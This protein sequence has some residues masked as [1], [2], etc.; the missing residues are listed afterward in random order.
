M[1]L[2][3]RVWWGFFFIILRTEGLYDLKRVVVIC[4]FVLD[5]VRLGRLSGNA[6]C[7]LFYILLDLYFMELILC[8]SVL[9]RQVYVFFSLF[10]HVCNRL[11]PISSFKHSLFMFMKYFC[12]WFPLLILVRLVVV[13]WYI[14]NLLYRVVFSSSG[15]A[16]INIFMEN[17]LALTSVLFC[18]VLFLFYIS[19]F[20][21]LIYIYIYIYIGRSKSP[22]KVISFFF[23]RKCF[24]Y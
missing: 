11:D 14:L 9:Q 18:F 20:L 16:L 3:S 19:F 24:F 6:F 12:W 2:T 21:F 7:S 10:C 23:S 4:S 17:I 22:I 5:C 13:P 15:L 8:I 1:L